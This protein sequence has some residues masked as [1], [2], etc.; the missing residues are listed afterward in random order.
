MNEVSYQAIGSIRTPFL[1]PEDCPIQPV[2]SEA[3]G[4][5][6]VAPEYAGGL[7]DIEGFT[8]VHLIHHLHLAKAVRL[9]VTP[10]LQDEER[11]VFATRAPCR[12]N[13]IGMSIVRL[14]RRE[15]RVLHVEGVDM[16]DGTPLL[17]VKPYCPRFDS[18]PGASSGWFAAVDD[19]TARHRGSRA[20]R[21][22]AGA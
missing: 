19:E 1:R 21:D 16:V 15:G 4:R 3:V 13:A 6:E 10:F 7:D 14:A 9:R 5:V 12:P 20:G 22:L 17:D 11:G 8:H 2:F 18:H